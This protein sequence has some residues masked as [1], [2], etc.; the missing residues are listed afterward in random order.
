ML[1]CR[2]GYGN[3]FVFDPFQDLFTHLIRDAIPSFCFVHN[4]IIS[5]SKEC[6][7]FGVPVKKK[8]RRPHGYR[9]LEVDTIVRFID[10]VKRYVLTGVDT[11][12]RTAFAACYTNHGSASAADFLRKA[13]V[14]LPDCPSAVQTDNGSEFSLHFEYAAADLSLTH[15]HIY[16]R[17]PKLN[18]HA[19]RFNRILDEEFL[20]CHRALMRD[21]VSAFNENLVD[22]LPWYNGERPHYALG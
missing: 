3:A 11:E 10:G 6:P 17:S 1:F 7:N 15:F 4:R 18:S 22:W 14:V 2:L 13:A 16:P 5:L 9:V 8:L 21:D 20:R 12:R 19:E